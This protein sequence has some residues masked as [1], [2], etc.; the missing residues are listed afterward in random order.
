MG[1]SQHCVLRD[2]NELV[3]I[4]WLAFSY[5]RRGEKVDFPEFVLLAPSLS[6]LQSREKLLPVLLI[7]R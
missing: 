7:C 5:T 3:T 4:A 6:L 2:K 1:C